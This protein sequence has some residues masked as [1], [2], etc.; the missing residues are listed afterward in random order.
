MVAV[1]AIAAVVVAV[2]TWSG[3]PIVVPLIVAAAVVAAVVVAV[4]VTWSWRRVVVRLLL[5]AAVAVADAD[6]ICFCYCC[7][8]SCTQPTVVDTKTFCRVGT[9]H[10]ARVRVEFRSATATKTS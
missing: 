3:C 10:I 9:A 8:V 1:V 6:A 4:V 2:V 7:P 5:V